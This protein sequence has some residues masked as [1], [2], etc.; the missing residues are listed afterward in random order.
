[1][2]VKNVGTIE[3]LELYKTHLLKGNTI[4]NSKECK[5]VYYE[6]LRRM[7][8]GTRAEKGMLAMTEEEERQCGFR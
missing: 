3:L 2:D 8:N 6:I 4:S 5:E 7:V 1:M